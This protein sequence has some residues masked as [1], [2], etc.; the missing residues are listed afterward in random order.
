MRA[1]ENAKM[2]KHNTYQMSAKHGLGSMGFLEVLDFIVNIV[3]IY[4]ALC[5]RMVDDD[6][7]DVKKWKISY[8]NYIQR[9]T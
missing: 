7:G 2:L 8:I 5:S 1:C 3:I 4:M 9:A 6:D